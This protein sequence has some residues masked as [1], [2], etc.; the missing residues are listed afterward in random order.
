MTLGFQL[1]TDQNSAAH[2]EGKPHGGPAARPPSAGFGLQ[3]PGSH[4]E[5]DPELA[6]QPSFSCT[7][8]PSV[9]RAILKNGASIWTT[10]RALN[11]LFIEEGV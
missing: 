8:L 2:D 4:L 1:F 10:T 3:A 6:G 9:K 5:P 7:S 11:E